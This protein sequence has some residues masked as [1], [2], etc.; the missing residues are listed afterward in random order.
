MDKRPPPHTVRPTVQGLLLSLFFMFGMSATIRAQAVEPLKIAVSRSPL[1]LPFFVAEKNGYFAA[2]GV[3]VKTS[4][5]IGGHR[6]LQLLLSGE[7]DLATSSDAV[8]M[9]NSFKTSD[10]AVIATFVS[11][12]D[13]IKLVVR[14]GAGIVLPNDLVGKR[15]GTVIGSAS[16]Y[17]LDTYLLFQGVDP[18]EVKVVGLQPEMM[19]AAMKSGAIDA[20][21]VWEPFPFELLQGIDGASLLKSPPA[22]R[23]TF[24]LLASRKIIG[25]RD[26]ELVGVLHALARAQHF[27]RTE[28]QMAQAI[29]RSQLKLNQA[30]IEWIWPSYNYRLTLDQSLLTTLESEGRWARRSGHVTAKQSPNYLDL[31]YTQPLRTLSPSSVGIVE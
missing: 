5:A 22:Y 18:Q 24:N 29:L 3:S 26:D 4:E 21:A 8:V 19:A 7:A 20:V 30:F 9:F 13:D 16:H 10:F 2:E 17:F 27:I 11:S 23:L 31:I 28:P 1:S 12:D 25:I 15:I 14:P 6:A